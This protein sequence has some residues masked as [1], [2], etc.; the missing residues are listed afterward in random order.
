VADI[1]VYSREKRKIW[2]QVS[3]SAYADYATKL[4]DLVTTYAID[5]MCLCVSVFSQMCGR[6][7]D[8]EK[9]EPDEFYLYI[10]TSDKRMT[11]VHQEFQAKRVANVRLV[12]PSS[13]AEFFGRDVAACFPT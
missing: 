2:I 10:T 12:P 13:F 1:F 3:E 11:E 4:P 6:E 5:P 7:N 9:L 8:H